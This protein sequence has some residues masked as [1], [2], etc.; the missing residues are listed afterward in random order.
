M[1]G[2]SFTSLSGNCYFYNDDTGFIELKPEVAY[3]KFDDHIE[4]RDINQTIKKEELEEFYYNEIIP[5]QLILEVTDAC[6]LR[7]KYCI[8]GDCY[9]ANRNH[10]EGIMSWEVAKKAIDY[11]FSL[12]KN[13]INKN[14][15]K[16]PT[17]GFYG[18]EP[19]LNFSLIK[20]VVSYIQEKYKDYSP[21]FNITTNG[22][23]LDGQVTSFIVDNDISVTISLDGSKEEHDRNRKMI[24]GKGSFNKVYGHI[25][26]IQE[27]YPAFDKMTISSCYDYKTDLKAVK[28]FFDEE[29]LLIVLF[30]LISENDTSYYK[31]FTKEDLVRQVEILE[32]LEETF[33]ELVGKGQIE[34]IIKG[35]YFP[36]FGIRYH[37]F[38][39]HAVYRQPRNPIIPFTGC[40]T[41]G[42]KLYV[43]V[44]GDLHMC[45][46]IS[47]Q[48]RIG[49]V[50]AGLDFERVAK[51][52]NAYRSQLTQCHQCP[53]SRLCG[54]CFATVTKGK[55]FK[56]EK[57]ACTRCIEQAKKTLR[58]YVNLMEKYPEQFQRLLGN[59][60]KQLEISSM[61]NPT[62]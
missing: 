27:Q 3:E 44:N 21:N 59:M 62:C 14:P 51:I 19:L 4:P 47:H 30:A 42:E 31:Q 60:T 57:E 43:S 39:L 46:K 7:C 37:N 49:D 29:D 45:E 16:Q 54:M 55:Q 61:N 11:Y 15:Q 9:D 28:N 24:N 58:G 34:K 6:N 53:V 32:E 22:M 8:Y 25:K 1:K 20:K 56:I 48:F 26:K 35:I 36:L 41:P 10:G 40:C 17:I 13:A 38:L 5:K 12:C 33:Y 2:I 23:L 50:E 52:V 18:G